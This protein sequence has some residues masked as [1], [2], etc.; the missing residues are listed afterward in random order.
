MARAERV[1][2]QKTPR[3]G[4]GLTG[5]GAFRLC[6]TCMVVC[7]CSSSFVRVGGSILFDADASTN[8]GHFSMRT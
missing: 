4:S 1:Y 7:T 8:N 3:L 6:R 2:L 5:C